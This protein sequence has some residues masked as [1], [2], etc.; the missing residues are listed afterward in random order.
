MKT[1]NKTNKRQVRRNRIRAKIS[2][3]ASMPRLSIF[4]SNRYISAQI[5]DDEKGRTLASGTGREFAKMKKSDQA[6]AVGKSIAKIAKEAKIARVAF[7]RGGYIYTGRVRA[8]ADAA[9]KE[10]LKF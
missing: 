6:V 7:D 1:S 4:K 2:G 3:T 9:R 8:L 10:G 5:I